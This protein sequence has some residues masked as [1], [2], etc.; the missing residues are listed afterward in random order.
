MAGL[1]D[2]TVFKL[3]LNDK[4]T[5]QYNGR[6]LERTKKHIVL[7]AFFDRA[8]MSFMDIILKQ[9]DRFVETYYSDR[10]YNIFEIYDRDDHKFKGCYCNICYPAVIENGKVSYV[11][12]ALDLW[13]ARDGT[14]TILDESEFLVLPID[15][16]IQIQAISALEELKRKFKGRKPPV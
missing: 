12:L 9:N 3:N 5:W 16:K 14:Q 13:I 4:V 7:E 1:T 10:W 2:I 8:D 11:D 15:N 6:V